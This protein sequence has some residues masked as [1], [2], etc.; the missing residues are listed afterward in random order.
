MTLMEKKHL[1]KLM[2]LNAFIAHSGFS[3]RRGADELI[4]KGGVKVNGAV[5][6]EPWLR[7]KDSD[8]VVVKGSLIKPKSFVYLAFYKPKGV[9]TTLRDKFAS[10][11]INDYL[12]DSLKGVYPVGRLDKYSEGLIILTNDGDL[13]YRLT[14]PKFRI[15][16]EYYLEV[17]GIILP[18]DLKKA[19]K[20]IYDE[21][22][23]LKADKIM[24]DEKD[25]GITRMRVIIHEGKKRELRRIFRKIGFGI[26]T[27]KRIRIANV[28]IGRLR[29]GE[30]RIV[31][32]RDIAYG[33]LGA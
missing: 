17:K 9:V 2:R 32:K 3:S 15:E 5:V 7:V 10:K 24:I 8:R 18:S 21:G 6:R 29:P 12:P 30:M 13:C 11:T 1:Q 25:K 27:L 22:E 14:H 19:L 4:K 23:L 20:G 31:R 16:K 33:T 26:V 28:H